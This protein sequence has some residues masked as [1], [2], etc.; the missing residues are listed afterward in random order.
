MND[1]SHEKISSTLTTTGIAQ[2]NLPIRPLMVMSGRNATTVVNTVA[3]T[4]PSSSTV[5]LTA[6]STGFMPRSM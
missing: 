6:A 5:P 2:M 3:A 4:G 1:S